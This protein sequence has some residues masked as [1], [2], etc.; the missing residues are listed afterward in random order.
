MSRGSYRIHGTNKPDSVGRL[1]SHGCF[2]LYP[3]DIAR[4]FDE[5]PV[6]TPVTV[7]NQ[8]VLVGWNDGELYLQVHPTQSQAV[9]LEDG[10]PPSPQPE[11]DVMQLVAAAAEAEVD[12]VDWEAVAMVAALHLGIPERITRPRFASSPGG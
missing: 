4:L 1:V 2:H 10:T 7:V 3:E 5:V 12:R 11:A 9:E 6:G 8:P